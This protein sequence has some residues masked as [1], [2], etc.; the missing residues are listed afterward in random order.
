M[1]VSSVS[2]VP[3]SLRRRTEEESTHTETVTF[4]APS[5]E[6]ICGFSR[7]GV[8]SAWV[9]SLYHSRACASNSSSADSVRTEDR[10]VACACSGSAYA[11]HRV[12]TTYWACAPA[13]VSVPIEP[14][15]L[16]GPAD[17][18]VMVLAT[19]CGPADWSSGEDW[20]PEAADVSESEEPVRRRIH[21]MTRAMI[22]RIA[23]AR[24]IFLRAGESESSLKSMCIPSIGY[25]ERLPRGSGKVTHE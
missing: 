24:S 15:A 25:R 2:A 12:L 13:S 5:S 23:A 10:S 14:D 20:M 9:R 1:R 21:E 7:V 19:D 6:M 18:G 11:F 8:P 4:P 16:A 22:R 17:C 3:A